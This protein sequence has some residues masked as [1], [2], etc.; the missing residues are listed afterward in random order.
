[1]SI[2]DYRLKTSLINV[3]YS[4]IEYISPALELNYQLKEKV[5]ISAYMATALAARNILASPN[6]GLG[7]YLK[8]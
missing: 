2:K 3:H 7:V 6:F 8:L 1:M 5:G 4:N